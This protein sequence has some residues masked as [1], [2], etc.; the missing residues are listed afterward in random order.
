LLHSRPRL[1]VPDLF[2]VECAGILCKAVRERRWPQARADRALTKLT[3]WPLVVTPVRELLTK[4]VAIAHAMKITAQDGCYVALATRE[5]I[6][7]V[8]D[9]LK[10][11]GPL[12]GTP[13][14][15][16]WLGDWKEG[17]SRRPPARPPESPVKVERDW[18]R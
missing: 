1:H 17:G 10:L 6:P 12:R 18:D 11:I 16:L 9:D 3:G 8:T 15:P 5:G 4:A 13:Y 2:F 7:L 14:E